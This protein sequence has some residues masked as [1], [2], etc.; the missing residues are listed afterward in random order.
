MKQIDISKMS[1]SERKETVKEAKI[2][3]VLSHPNIVKFIE[4]FKTKSGKLC[5][6]MDF[7]DG[8][9]QQKITYPLNDSLMAKESY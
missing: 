3:E 6:V 9:P 2:L 7:A 5:I 1:E 8:K 4:V